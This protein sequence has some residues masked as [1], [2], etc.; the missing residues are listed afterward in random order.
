ML[1]KDIW[2][3]FDAGYVHNAMH[4]NAKHGF[5]QITIYIHVRIQMHIQI[6]DCILTHTCIHMYT[7]DIPW[8]SAKLIQY[9]GPF[10]I[11]KLSLIYSLGYV[12][13]PIYSSLTGNLII[14]TQPTGKIE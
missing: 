8:S 2:G 14:R 9:F 11:N 13:V 10:M 5:L 3:Y 1:Q 6:Q 12:Y 4:Y 7:Y